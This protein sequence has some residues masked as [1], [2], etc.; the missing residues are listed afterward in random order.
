MIED[1]NWRHHMG[2]F[3]HIQIMELLQ[4]FQY[5]MVNYIGGERRGGLRR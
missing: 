5:D 3:N 1:L 4:G 2:G